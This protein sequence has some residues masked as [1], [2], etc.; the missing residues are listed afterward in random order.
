MFSRLELQNFR[1]YKEAGFDLGPGVNVII[2]PNASGKTNLLEALYVLSRGSSFRTDDTALIRAGA[3]WSRVDAMYNDDQ[4]TIKLITTNSS[5]RKTYL[6]NDK[7]VKHHQTSVVLFEPDQLRIVHGPPDLRRAWVD[8]LI[9]QTDQ[10]YQDA[11]DR[12]TRAL[13]QRNRLLKNNAHPD[14]LFV[15]EIKLSE[16]GSQL[17]AKRL[18]LIHWLNQK[19]EPLYQKLANNKDKISL[20][21]KSTLGADY[22]SELLLGLQSRRDRDKLI[23]F[24]TIGPHRDDIAIFFNGQLLS[25]TASRGER[26]TLYLC[27]KFLEAQWLQE[28]KNDT[29]IL[30]LDDLFGELD[31]KRKRQLQTILMGHQIIITSTDDHP[32]GNK[33]G[34]SKRVIKL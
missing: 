2:G 26:R 14:E 25:E 11:L 28:H 9:G 5:P 33:L 18:S 1:S 22:G 19:I 20:S 4:I 15:W 8:S 23:G 31:D 6:K 3:G 27:L 13:R 34:A 24:T 12:Y 7:A 16:Y 29:P 32:V 10:L 30:L 17:V 21:Y